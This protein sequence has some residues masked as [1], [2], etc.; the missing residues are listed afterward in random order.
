MTGG[1]STDSIDI[2]K[3]KCVPLDL[4]RNVSDDEKVQFTV[5]QNTTTLKDFKTSS[6]E[7]Q[8]A[9]GPLAGNDTFD[10][11]TIEN[12]IIGFFVAFGIL[13]GIT[14]LFYLGLNLTTYGTGTF[15]LPPTLRGLPV[16]MLVGLLFLVLGFLVGYFIPR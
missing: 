10:A 5:N 4:L 11:D 2:S 8:M 15:G 14:M 1:V 3:Y 16:I 12:I 7:A 13:F 9:A 6:D